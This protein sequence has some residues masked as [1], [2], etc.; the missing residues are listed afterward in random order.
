MAYSTIAG[1]FGRYEIG[2]RPRPN[3]FECRAGA[4]QCPRR[5]C[6]LAANAAKVHTGAAAWWTPNGTPHGASASG[7]CTTLVFGPFM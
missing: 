5:G 6:V 7:N 4:P 2:D 1:I 3:N